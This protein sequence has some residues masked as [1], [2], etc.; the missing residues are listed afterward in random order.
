MISAACAS[1]G[2]DVQVLDVHVP[3]FEGTGFAVEEVPDGPR[4]SGLVDA[5]DRVV[6][7]DRLNLPTRCDER[8]AGVGAQ[9][10]P[11]LTDHLEHR[12]PD[13]QP[14]YE[15]VFVIV[16]HGHRCH[17]VASGLALP[18]RDLGG[19]LPEVHS[20][21][22][23]LRAVWQ[24]AEERDRAHRQTTARWLGLRICG[25]DFTEYDVC[26]AAYAWIVDA[27]EQI[28]LSWFNG[29]GRSAVGH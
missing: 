17:E 11:V 16:E 22:S 1:F 3:T 13:S 7:P 29:G 26:L 21:H 10:A 8:I 27:E 15:T 12:R 14:G 4:A 6:I 23:A 28:L 19:W 2:S 18:P 25:M 5:Q 20:R 9:V 24:K